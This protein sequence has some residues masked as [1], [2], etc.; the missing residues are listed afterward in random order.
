M[1]PVRQRLPHDIPLWVDPM[2]EIYFLTLTCQLRGQNTLA[3]DE[4]AHRLFESI[5]QVEQAGGWYNYLLM[6]MPD[7]L[8]GL[9]RFGASPRPMRRVVSDWKRWTARHLGIC[10]QRDFFEHRLRRDESLCDKAA[11]ILE[12]PVRAGLVARVE[13]W[14][15]VRFGQY[16]SIGER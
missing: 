10:W 15:F 13:D 14:P 1:L 4:V 6:L 3:S 16:A 12:N 2:Q 7:H 5:A 9:F 11:Y 8:H